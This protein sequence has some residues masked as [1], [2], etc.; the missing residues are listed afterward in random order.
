VNNRLIAL[1]LA[2]SD[3]LCVVRASSKT[4]RVWSS[5]SAESLCHLYNRQHLSVAETDSLRLNKR[6]PR[7]RVSR[8]APRRHSQQL[9]PG[10]GKFLPASC[11]DDAESKLLWVSALS[12]GAYMKIPSFIAF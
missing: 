12:G 6:K 7:G 4:L 10:T 11:E 9:Q 3:G 2:R 5:E 8:K 1:S